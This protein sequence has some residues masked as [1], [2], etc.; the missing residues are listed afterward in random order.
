MHWKTLQKIH[1]FLP[2]LLRF[3]ICPITL[4]LKEFGIRLILNN[5][6]TLK[7]VSGRYGN[8]YGSI[9]TIFKTTSVPCMTGH[10]FGRFPLDASIFTNIKAIRENPIE[11]SAFNNSHI[12]TSFNS[13]RRFKVPRL[14]TNIMQWPK[15]LEKLVKVRPWKCIP[16]FPFWLSISQCLNF[17]KFSWIEQLADFNTISYFWRC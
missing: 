8:K 14:S 3:F 9:L 4:T 7:F 5:R 17:P 10:F 2:N 16:V 12:F 1:H 15:K 6:S 11:S 13:N